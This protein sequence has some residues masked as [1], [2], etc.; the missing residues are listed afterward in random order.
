MRL[1]L[2]CP[3]AFLLAAC[4]SASPNEQGGTPRFDASAPT[5]ASSEDG[6]CG[7]TDFDASEGTGWSDLYRDYFGPTGVASCA[8]TA[9]ACHGD[10]NSLGAQNS[11]YVCSGTV[12]GCYAGITSTAA[13]LVTVGDTTDDPTTSTLYLTL[14]K[15]CGGG[16]MPK[17]PAD[18]FFSAADMKRIADWI[19]AGAPNN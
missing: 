19:G 2:A 5:S 13:D 11:G 15:A 16:V 6:G 9:A 4:S 14:R 10:A 17:E 3:F 12:A 18:F 8:G 7:S 1:L